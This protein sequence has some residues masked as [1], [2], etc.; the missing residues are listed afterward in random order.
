M[1]NGLWQK[2]ICYALY[3]IRNQ[4]SVVGGHLHMSNYPVTLVDLEQGAVIIGGGVVAARKAQG[5]LDA[6]AR[7]T[8][9][10]PQLTSELE[11]LAR[12]ERV[13]V[14]RRAYQT[15]DLKNARVIIAATGDPPINQA[16]YHEARAHGI[17][18]NVVDDPMHCTVHIPAVVR[19][20]AI[21]IAISTSGA[22]PA[23]VK[24]LREEIENIIGAEYARLA[25]LLA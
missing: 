15:G 22:S 20:G 11:E 12:D 18:V 14:I 24:R 13:D 1:A 10:A 17:L 19:R 6:G 23:L 2:A 25:A 5:L 16:V 9:I 4:Q 3:A 8:V 7:V 21:A